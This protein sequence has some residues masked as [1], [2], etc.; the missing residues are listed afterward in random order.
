MNTVL[1]KVQQAR[2]QNHTPC[3]SPLGYA[4]KSS[5]SYLCSQVSRMD[6]S[7]ALGGRPTKGSGSGGPGAMTQMGVMGNLG[8]IQL[9]NVGLKASLRVIETNESY[10]A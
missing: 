9:S 5:V 4:S 8:T 10:E 7:R 6:G 3:S 2:A 1:D